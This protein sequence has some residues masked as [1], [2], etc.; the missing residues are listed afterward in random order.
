MKSLRKLVD[1]LVEEAR[2][3]PILKSIKSSYD[4][5]G[6]MIERLSKEE[7]KLLK[8]CT[9]KDFNGRIK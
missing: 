7:R 6:K 4:K 3:E 9:S 2:L 5:P 1:K 8:N